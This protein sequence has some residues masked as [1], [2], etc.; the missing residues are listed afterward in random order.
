M[1]TEEFMSMNN[2]RYNPQ[3]QRYVNVQKKKQQRDR[4]RLEREGRSKKTYFILENPLA[5]KEETNGST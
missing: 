4:E 5:K 2:E 3:Y 1:T